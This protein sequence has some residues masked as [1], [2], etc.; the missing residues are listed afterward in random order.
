M[1]GALIKLSSIWA[2]L[3][4]QTG[5]SLHRSRAGLVVAACLGLAAAILLLILT[6]LISGNLQWETAVAG[7]VIF[8]LTALIVG[9]QPNPR[10]N[11]KNTNFSTD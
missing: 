7:S 8:L 5:D 6:W 3:L 2:R 1:Y 10:H 4:P 9:L 11:A